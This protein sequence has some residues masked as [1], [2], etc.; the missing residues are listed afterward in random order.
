MR[1]WLKSSKIE[2]RPT[3][4]KSLKPH[5]LIKEQ[6]RLNQN[7]FLLS[8]QPKIKK[9]S[10]EK[11]RKEAERLGKLAEQE[12]EEANSKA[13][14]IDELKQQLKDIRGELGAQLHLKGASVINVSTKALIE[15]F[16]DEAGANEIRAKA[17]ELEEAMATYA[18]GVACHAAQVLR[19]DFKISG[20][21]ANAIVVD[22]PDSEPESSDD[23]LAAYVEVPVAPEGKTLSPEDWDAYRK[24]QTAH[25]AMFKEREAKKKE[26]RKKKEG[27]RKAVYGKLRAT[28]SSSDSKGVI[29]AKK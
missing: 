14:E 22:L 9:A 10:A 8:P 25:A 6:K 2:S 17:R 5:L 4:R 19:G 12:E 7:L 20:E 28:A 21:T 18:S 1:L 16:P 26:R 11:N 29:A 15:S 24:K 27:E 13:A 23:E 3:K